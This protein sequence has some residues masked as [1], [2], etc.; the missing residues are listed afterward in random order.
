MNSKISFFT[1][2]ATCRKVD[3]H[4]CFCLATLLQD[5]VADGQTVDDVPVHPGDEARAILPDPMDNVIRAKGTLPVKLQSNQTN[6]A[7]HS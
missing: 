2:L 5:P 6:E 7:Q 4:F 3:V 1:E